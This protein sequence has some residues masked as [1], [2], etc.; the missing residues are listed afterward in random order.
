TLKAVW[1]WW[2]APTPLRKSPP[3]LWQVYRLRF[4]IEHVRLFS[5]FIS[6]RAGIRL[7]IEQPPIRRISTDLGMPEP[8]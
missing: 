7:P 6:S 1:L 5:A 8:V 3:R 4:D 2:Q